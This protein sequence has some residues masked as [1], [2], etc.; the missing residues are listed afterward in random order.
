MI[1]KIRKQFILI[2]M[3]SLVAVFTVIIGFINITSYIRITDKAD[4][5]LTYLADNDGYFP[6]PDKPDRA[7]EKRAAH[8]SR[9]SLEAPFDTRYFSV[10]ISHTGEVLE[11]NTGNIFAVSSESAVEYAQDVLDSRAERGYQEDYRYSI[12]AVPEG[13]M[14]LFLDNSR[15]MNSFMTFLGA[16]ILIS[17]IGIL[18]VFI[19]VMLLSKRAINPIAESYEKQKRFI[20]DA[21]HE[22]KTPL[23]IIAANTEV[24]V[25][26]CGES[27]WTSSIRNQ[28]KRLTELTNNLVALSRMDETGSALIMTEFSLSDAVLESA[29][30]FMTLAKTNGKSI[31]TEV[32]KKVSYH[33][34][35]QSLRNLVGILLD[36]AIKYSS[37]HSD[38]FLSLKL[39]G[40]AIIL[41]CEN[42]VD[43]IEKGS[44]NELFD[45]FYRGDK[46]RNSENGGYGIGLSLAEAIVETHKGKISARS[47]NGKS[48]T[49]T[50]I[51]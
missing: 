49:I 15:E 37:E 45:R 26:E 25:M 34:D 5:L 33:G 44:N 6:K 29:E 31:Y 23:T 40:K 28:V 13:N 8:S 46:S 43:E 22:I 17:V 1:K 18:A 3:C 36:N 12:Q 7:N 11:I 27:E 48:L 10:I 9:F 16:S 19:L 39:Q 24:I 41:S 35:E 32:E 2:T 14:V 47:E 51:L 21:G 38:I 4:S 42:S 50:A 20:T 30:P